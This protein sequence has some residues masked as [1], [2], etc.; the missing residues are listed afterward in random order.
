MT[1][2]GVQICFL[3][4]F[5]VWVN[6]SF[7]FYLQVGQFYFKKENFLLLPHLSQIVHPLIQAN[8]FRI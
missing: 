7:Y 1:D 5:H 8:A 4:I 2:K 3:I 6:L